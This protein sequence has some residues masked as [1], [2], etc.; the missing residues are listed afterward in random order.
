MRKLMWFTIGFAA[1]CAVGA[2]LFLDSKLLICAVICAVLGVL[3]WFLPQSWGKP[4]AVV[5]LGCCIGFC[6]IFGYQQ[7][8]LQP[9]RKL[10]GQTI[11]LTIET[12]DYSQK[13]A[14]G[15]SADGKVQIEGKDFK[16]RFYLYQEE[17]LEPGD[18]V[19]GTFRVRLTPFASKQDPTHHQGEGIF[20]LAYGQE[21]AEVQKGERGFFTYFAADLRQKILSVLDAVFPEDTL[22]FA[23]ALLLGDTSKLSA[24][25]DYAMQVS[26]IRHII[27]VS[28][29]HVSILFSFL[30]TLVGRRRYLTSL[31]CIPALLLFAAVA[32]FTPSI[33]R[34]C[35]MQILMILALLLN[36]EYDPPTA[37]AFAVLLMLVV[38]PFAITSASLQLSAGCIVGIFLF[39]HRISGFLQ[40]EK[41]LGSLKG[42]SRKAKI[43]R[44]TVSCISVTLST[45]IVTT[46]LCALYFQQISLIGVLTNLLTLWVVTF[47]FCG[48]IFVCILGAL[49][50]PLGQIAAFAVSIPMRYVLGISDLLAKFPLAAVHTASVYMVVWVIFC[51]VAFAV[52]LRMKKKRL[53]VFLCCLAVS[54][55][56]CVGFSW[57]EPRMDNY[58]LTVFDVGQG[59]CILLQSKGESYLI[60]CGGDYGENA[61]QMA[62]HELLSQ[63]IFQLDGLILTHYDTDHTGGVEALLD[64]ISVDRFYLPEPTNEDALGYALKEE[65]G[66]AVC[67]VTETQQFS[68]GTAEITVVPSAGAT[69]S[70]ERSLCIL[71]QAEE[72]DILITGDRTVSGEQA[73]LEQIELPKLE[74]LVVG[75][76]GSDSSTGLA[77]L[78]ATRPSLAVISVG[79]DNR[80]GHPDK[81]VLRILDLFGCYIMRTD[82]DGTIRIRG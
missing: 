15:I 79:E 63:G 41:R 7:I 36:R 40:N 33:T 17:P 49:W 75:H 59:Q 32:G 16:V 73:L 34:A 12:T 50:L 72:C 43:K 52:F 76:H 61:A 6:W 3:A 56:V 25:T 47:I 38:N 24:K 68:C 57:A 58:R 82:M 60:D 37:L 31:V 81:M 1:A 27:A 28:G 46:P 54:F 62:A 39:Y 26:G 18:I 66:S 30:Y 5:L 64:R 21:G 74:V 2:Y 23:R 69:S 78:T 70:N 35:V 77:L 71:F 45:M 13:T 22:G 65:Y 44:G 53:A 51:Y 11:E 19:E 67:Y 14:Y 20:L 29:L 8:R 42:K 9:A 80:Y 10:D 4:A 48:I 55:G